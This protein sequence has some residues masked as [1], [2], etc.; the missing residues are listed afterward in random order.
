MPLS[1]FTSLLLCVLLIGGAAACSSGNNNAPAAAKS[2]AGSVATQAAPPAA[3]T[4]TSAA[5]AATP[6]RT[7]AAAATPAQTAAATAAVTAAASAA[8]VVPKLPATVNDKDGH[9]VTITSID[10]VI[11]LNGEI[12]EIMFEL[13]LGDKVAGADISSTYPPQVSKLP[14]IG[15]QRTLSAE[16]ILA[17]KPTLVIGNENAGP[18]PVID[19]IR[20][21]G[22]PILI[23]KYEA[24]LATIPDKITLIASALGVPAQGT[25]LVAKLQ[26]DITTAKALAAS[27]TSK[28]KVAFLNLRGPGTQQIWGK[29]FPS[30]EMIVAA[31]AVDAATVAG[32]DGSKPITAEALV[33][34][35][36][37]V[38]LTTTTALE[39]TGGINGLL[40]IPG[41][42]QTP[43]GENKRVL[44]YEDQY[45]LG[46]GPRAGQALIELVRALHPEVK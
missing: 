2:P 1:R 30:D 34:A 19:Q 16:A 5:I 37:D 28:P 41:I 27:A 42:A 24:T 44:A 4:A 10:R 26:K 14:S 17:L 18:Q 32:I 12:T 25:A 38:I 40:Q 21:A 15:Y 3:A 31:G 6:A 45:L 33:T 22:V 23:F 8:A 43:A 11:P 9:P 13:G 46:M 35:Q 20:S 7:A 36:P 39:G 29:G